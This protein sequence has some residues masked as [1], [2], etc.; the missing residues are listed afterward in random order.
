M[1]CSFGLEAVQWVVALPG[2]GVFGFLVLAPSCGA[3]HPAG[4]EVR[5]EPGQVPE[6][7]EILRAQVLA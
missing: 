7:R 2:K 4:A 5:R 3:S 6:N 1:A